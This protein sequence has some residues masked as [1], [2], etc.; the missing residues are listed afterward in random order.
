MN[1][2]TKMIFAQMLDIM[3]GIL[4]DC[5]SGVNQYLTF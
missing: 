3:F 5:N 2:C 4:T 1:I